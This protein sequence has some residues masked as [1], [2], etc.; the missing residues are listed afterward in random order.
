MGFTEFKK[1]LQ[2]QINSMLEDVDH[3]FI[4]DVDKDALWA[5]YLNSFPAGTN[6]IFRKKPEFECSACRH[7]IKSFGAVVTIKNNKVTTVWDFETDDSTYQPVISALSNF[8]KS[9]KVKDVFITK[10]AIFGMDKNHERLENGK[11]ITWEHLYYKLPTKF[12][13]T[14]SLSEEAVAGQARDI[15]NVFKRSLDEIS[16]DA[17]ETILELIAQNSLYK[18][19]EWQAVLKQFLS[20]QK[21]YSKLSPNEEKELFCWE[22]SLKVGPVIGKIRN[23]SI[24][25]LLTDVTAGVDLDKAVRS[26]ESLVAP[27]NYKR[28]QAI[29]TKKMLEDA[30]KKLEELGY[31]A[32]LERRFATLDDITVNNVLFANRDA[33]KRMG[34]SSIFDSMGQDMGV[35]P[36][37]FD[38]VEEVSIET[39]IKDILP[40]IN[41]LEVLMENKHLA[42]LVSLIAPMNKEAQS[43]FKWGNPFSW[44]YTGNITDSM[45]ERVK[46]AGGR[47]DGDLR[48]S[49]QWN[50]DPKDLNQNDFDAHCKEPNGEEI[51]FMCP[52]RH[53]SGGNLDVDIRFPLKGQVAVENITWPDRSRMPEGIYTFFVE[54]FRHNGGRTGFSA[55]IEFD[56]QI[57]SFQYDRELRQKEVVQVAKVSYSRKE[58]FK[59]IEV[60]PSS[61]SP[62]SA[63][64]IKTNQF[65]PVSVCMFSPNYWDAQEGIGNK[66][67]FFMLKNC[68]NSESPNGFFNEYLKEEL[69]S[70]KRVLEAL[71]AKMRVQD[72]EDQLSGIGFSSTQRNT[73]VCKIE[74][75]VSRTLKI[76]F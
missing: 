69:L 25:V 54:N 21:E 17:V 51:Y 57:H 23:H 55:E 13:D 64:G 41:S 27:A 59:L 70:H 19:E 33:V 42:N 14:S 65:I 50:D 1:K 49:I 24:G 35:N 20:L 60:L 72:V 9:H 31:M 30:Q 63:W 62:R 36:K 6:A 40:T 16:K 71:G 12:I 10:E 45:K 47:V 58:G 73:L 56:G 38:R 46:S 75:R 15:R 11:V 76:S 68:V 26:F 32:S 8:V 29:F 2:D 74:G 5:M 4:M 48:F 53:R 39:F 67:Y 37:S 44:A 43:M 34:G 52:S 61:S 22:K 28:P 66:H 3:L 18:G 7:F